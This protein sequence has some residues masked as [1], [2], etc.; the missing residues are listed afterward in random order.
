MRSARTP[1]RSFV[2]RV[3]NGFFGIEIA[4]DAV[5][6]KFRPERVCRLPIYINKAD[7][8][9]Q[10]DLGKQLQSV[11]TEITPLLSLAE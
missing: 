9:S 10:N 6:H 11:D 7:L 8:K 2:D 4:D 1:C 5:K 3:C